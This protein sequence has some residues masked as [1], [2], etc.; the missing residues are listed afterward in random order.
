M[1]VRGAMWTKKKNIPLLFL[2]ICQLWGRPL[3]VGAGLQNWIKIPTVIHKPV[4][5]KP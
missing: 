2:E 4:F 5:Y 1:S 3:S